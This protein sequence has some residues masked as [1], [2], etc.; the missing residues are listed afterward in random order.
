MTVV[1]VTGDVKQGPLDTAT[2]PHTYESYKQLGALMSLR[3]ALRT[4]R[5]PTSLAADLRTAVWSLDQRL[6]PGRIR[7]MEQVI[8]QSTSTR[9]FNLFL[10]G[11]FAILA[12]ALSAIGIY[13]I[14]A[15]SVTRRTHEIG[16]RMA[17]GATRGDI[18][19]LV[20]GPGT[21][22]T[23]VGIVLGVAGALGVTRLL[24]A[25]LFEVRPT[26]PATFA[27]VLL[28]LGGVALTASCLPARRAMRIEPVAALRRE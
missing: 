2:V 20:L 13:G 15:Y 24:E 9:R 19:R 12:L 14:V 3:V 28:L 25:L 26:D 22:V 10:L 16:L 17:L 4:E 1:G 8:A 7:T 6:A 11:S 18:I 21:R 5:D 23:T 27:A